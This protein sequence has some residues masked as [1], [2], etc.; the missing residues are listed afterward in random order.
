LRRAMTE[1]RSFSTFCVRYHAL[2]RY[3]WP[4]R[5]ERCQAPKSDTARPRFSGRRGRHVRLSDQTRTAARFRRAVT[6]VS[7]PRRRLRSRTA[8]ARSCAAPIR[9]EEKSAARSQMRA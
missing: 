9:A 3:V 4:A 6:S 8:T 1:W 7:T 2:K 5:I